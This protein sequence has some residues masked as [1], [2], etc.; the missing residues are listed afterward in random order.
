MARKFLCLTAQGN[1]DLTCNYWKGTREER[2]SGRM[3]RGGGEDVWSRRQPRSAAESSKNET[4][5]KAVWFR[6]CLRLSSRGRLPPAMQSRTLE[7]SSVVHLKMWKMTQILDTFNR[8]A[9]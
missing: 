7:L 2:G 6:S 9:V 5:W 8:A 4:P 3:K 1:I